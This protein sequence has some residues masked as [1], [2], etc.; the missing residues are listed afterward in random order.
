MRPVLFLTLL[1]SSACATGTALAQSGSNWVDPPAKSGPSATEG[2][3]AKPSAKPGPR[4]EAEAD[5]RTH[6]HRSAAPSPARRE[7]RRHDRTRAAEMRRERRAALRERAR[8]Q[9]QAHNHA[10]TARTER[11]AERPAPPP[12]RM[13]RSEP[14]PRFSD[15]AV[16]A[17]RLSLDYLDSVSAPNG[18]MLAS[19]PRFY[20][21]TVRFH[22]RVMS[23]GALLAEKR[24]FARR[25]PERRYE[26]QGE[27]RVACDGASATCLVRIV[28]DFT[29]LSPS[30][31]GRSQGVAE[32]VLTVSFAGG[33]PVIVAESSR[34]LSRAGA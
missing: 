23:I 34:V 15:W 14:D 11:L 4:F 7:T 27:P 8:E 20:G 21:G 13:G 26:P 24:R 1:L 22:G 2:E 17:R 6:A 10:H 28:H 5:G 33:P 30:R 16:T 3:R 25:W 12:A 19:A 31:G 29:A 9:G 32:L 18:T